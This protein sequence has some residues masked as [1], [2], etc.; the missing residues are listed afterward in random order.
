LSFPFCFAARGYR[1]IRTGG[2]E[3]SIGPPYSGHKKVT[4]LFIKV[5]AAQQNKAISSDF[6][7]SYMEK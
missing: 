3:M 2:V 7:N 5:F 6:Q 1:K 4:P